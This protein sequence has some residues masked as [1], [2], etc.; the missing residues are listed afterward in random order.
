MD[1]LTT[2]SGTPRIVESW[3]RDHDAILCQLWLAGSSREEIAAT[4]RAHSGI[5]RSLASIS[6]RASRL[7]LPPRESGPGQAPRLP[8][9]LPQDH[10]TP[11]IFPSAKLRKCLGPQCGKDFWSEHAGIRLCSS[12]SDRIAALDD[13][14]SMTMALCTSW[15]SPRRS[16]L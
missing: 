8:R 15:R 3:A 14:T 1:A 13:G 6:T 16:R 4:L 5:E 10:L 11:Q 7:G 2:A 9:P 12:C